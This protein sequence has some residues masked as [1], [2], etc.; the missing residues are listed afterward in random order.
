MRE[1]AASAKDL[2]SLKALADDI[3]SRI[4]KVDLK[5]YEFEKDPD[6]SFRHI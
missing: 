4:D 2:E 1:L 5:S 3:L 6:L